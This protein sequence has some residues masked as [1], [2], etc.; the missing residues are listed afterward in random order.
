[1][2]PATLVGP[3]ESTKSLG[4]L[5]S[6]FLALILSNSNITAQ[7]LGCG[8]GGGVRSAFPEL[9]T[10]VAK[11][12]IRDPLKATGAQMMVTSCPLCNYNF[13]SVGEIEVVDL[14]EFLLRAWMSNT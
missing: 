7:A 13:K 12:I 6:W 8:S 2:T 4:C 5:S 3:W 10:E 11:A 9:S 14:S 1:M